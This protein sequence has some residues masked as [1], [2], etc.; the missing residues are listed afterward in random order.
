MLHGQDDVVML[1]VPRR[2]LVLSTSGRHGK[3]CG[4]LVGVLGRQ[5][6]C[7]QTQTLDLG[8]KHMLEQACQI[9]A[10]WLK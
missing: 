7:L 10:S 4:E 2:S 8:A 9:L 5:N 6:A 1:V 3:V